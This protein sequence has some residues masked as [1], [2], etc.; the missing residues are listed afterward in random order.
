MHNN[1]KSIV[2]VRVIG[3][4]CRVK[5]YPCCI[6]IVFEQRYTSTK[7]HPLSIL[8][9]AWNIFICR[10][11]FFILMVFNDRK[12]GK[13]RAEP[14]RFLPSCAEIASATRSRKELRS[15]C[16]TRL[17]TIRIN[18]VDRC[19]RVEEAVIQRVGPL[20]LTCNA[21]VVTAMCHTRRAAE[22]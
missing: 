20:Y 7:P 17:F 12:R 22:V 3:C 5:Y 13:A 16:M 15:V 11:P 9:F 6:R 1:Y 21:H 14:F 10:R 18:C 19:S 8:T 4:N 2:Y